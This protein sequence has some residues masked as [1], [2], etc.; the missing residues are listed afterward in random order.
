[1][2]TPSVTQQYMFEN[3]DIQVPAPLDYG[4]WGTPVAPTVVPP[5]P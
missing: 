4:V 5:A 1:V 2:D 3:F